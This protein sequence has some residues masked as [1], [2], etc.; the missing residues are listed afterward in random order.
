MRV[1][2][3]HT[4]SRLVCLQA[5]SSDFVAL[6]KKSAVYSK[7]EL[8]QD[9]CHPQKAVTVSAASAATCTQ[10]ESCITQRICCLY[11]FASKKRKVCCRYER[12]CDLY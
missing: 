1:T 11:N 7:T 2:S 6:V 3:G 4:T 8:K 9:S 10:Q 12:C 5:D